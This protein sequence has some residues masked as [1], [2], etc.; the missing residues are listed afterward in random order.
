MQYEIYPNNSLIMQ[1]VMNG[2]RVTVK[3]TQE[4]QEDNQNGEYIFP[5]VKTLLDWVGEYYKEKE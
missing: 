3:G 1:K 4:M 2:Y 5:S